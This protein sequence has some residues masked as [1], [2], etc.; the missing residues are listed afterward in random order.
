MHAHLSL[1][2]LLVKGE[3]LLT[4]E[5]FCLPIDPSAG[6]PTPAL[7]LGAN[8]IVNQWPYPTQREALDALVGSREVR[9][10]VEEKALI[11]A[12]CAAVNIAG[13]GLGWSC[14]ALVGGNL[15]LARQRITDPATLQNLAAS[16][17][18]AA[19][20]SALALAGPVVG[21]CGFVVSMVTSDQLW[22]WFIDNPQALINI[23]IT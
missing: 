13:A 16:A 8:P 4:T 14:G 1:V 18:A 9:Q 7:P 3:G 15:A 12:G 2:C 10:A 20:C 23:P 6:A 5:P 21:L 19:T 11:M 17:A 22:S